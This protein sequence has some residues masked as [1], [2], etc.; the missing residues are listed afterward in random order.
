VWCSLL[1]KYKKI[2]D[3][4]ADK[5]YSGTMSGML[6]IWIVSVCKLIV[7][8]ITAEWFVDN[9]DEVIEFCLKKKGK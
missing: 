6:K 5:H 2:L 1:P 4:A 9:I 7:S 8:G 3:K